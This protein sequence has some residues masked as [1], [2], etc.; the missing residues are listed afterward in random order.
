MP[1][2]HHDFLS[3][4]K[5]LFSIISAHF[6]V[7]HARLYIDVIFLKSF[8]VVLSVILS[9]ILSDILSVI[10]SFFYVCLSFLCVSFRLYISAHFPTCITLT[11]PGHSFLS[12]F[13]SLQR[14]Q[15]SYL[16]IYMPFPNLLFIFCC[17]CLSFYT[18]STFLSTLLS[19]LTFLFFL[20]F[21]YS[22]LQ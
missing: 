10:L 5:T 4:S 1:V 17:F 11:F 21:C 9:D 2:F 13:H 19:F 8:S 18:V 15:I 6:L 12:F 22:L 7:A 14:G 20:S 3:L 16:Y